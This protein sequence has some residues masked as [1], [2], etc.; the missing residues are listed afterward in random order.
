MTPAQKLEALDALNAFKSFLRE[1][2][3]SRPDEPD[4]NL[5][6]LTMKAYRDGVLDEDETL[7]N[8]VS[9]L[10]AG[11]ETTVTLIG[12]GMLLLLRNPD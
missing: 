1:Q 2:I 4:D 7:T 5:M 8:L 3:A 9:M 6:G 10:I 12:N 11:H